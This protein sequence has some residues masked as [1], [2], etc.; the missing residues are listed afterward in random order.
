MNCGERTNMLDSTVKGLSFF[1]CLNSKYPT[2]QTAKDNIIQAFSQGD[3]KSPFKLIS[4]Q[5][6]KI[7]SFNHSHHLTFQKC[8]EIQLV[9]LLQP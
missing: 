5:L 6:K 8:P 2:L 9:L 1:E 7:I 3:L 4:A